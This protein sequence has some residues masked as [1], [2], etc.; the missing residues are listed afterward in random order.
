MY[1]ARLHKRFER[2][3]L[4]VTG[5]GMYRLAFDVRS[6][7]DE[8]EGFIARYAGTG[9]CRPGAGE[10]DDAA[11]GT[12]GRLNDGLPLFLYDYSVGR[13]LQPRIDAIIEALGASGG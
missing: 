12:A 10:C 6:D 7:L 4:I 1:V 5:G 11:H 3:D 13:A 9:S 2:T 8:I